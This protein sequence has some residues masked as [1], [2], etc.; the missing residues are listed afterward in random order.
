[1]ALFTVMALPLAGVRADIDLPVGA[2]VGVEFTRPIPIQ[3]LCPQ[4]RRQSLRRRVHHGE[5]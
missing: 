2:Q 4:P 1:M 5:R 3:T